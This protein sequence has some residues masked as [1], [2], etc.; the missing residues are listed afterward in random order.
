MKF[1]HQAE[2]LNGNMLMK[3][4]LFLM[5]YFRINNQL[6][7]LHSKTIYI[8]IY[9]IFHNAKAK[10]YVYLKIFVNFYL[11]CLMKKVYTDD[12]TYYILSYD[13]N[14][15]NIESTERF[16]LCF[17]GKLM[18]MNVT[19]EDMSFIKYSIILLTPVN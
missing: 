11:I 2:R 19:E 5:N 4:K 16:I 9:I 1:D 6:V 18:C 12:K 14:P 3:L 8:T 15:F 7:H 17:N 10:Q 13:S